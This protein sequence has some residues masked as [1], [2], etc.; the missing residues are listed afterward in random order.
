MGRTAEVLG[1]RSAKLRTDDLGDFELRRKEKSL[2]VRVD[3]LGDFVLKREEK[4]LGVRP[5]DLGGNFITI[6]SIDCGGVRDII[7]TEVPKI[8]LNKDTR[9]AYYFDFIDGT[10]TRGLM[11][12][13]LATP[14]DEN[15]LCLLHKILPSFITTID[16]APVISLNQDGLA[17]V[18]GIY[19]KKWMKFKGSPG[20]TTKNLSRGMVVTQLQ[21]IEMGNST[22]STGTGKL[23]RL[24][25]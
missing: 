7:P 5:D 19:K 13:T 11:T 12:S 3:D 14:N 2:G 16:Q 23:I 8:G 24:I 20:T 22:T 4:I 1:R 10:S 9:V 17:V 21:M 25:D 15:D 18:K 6:L